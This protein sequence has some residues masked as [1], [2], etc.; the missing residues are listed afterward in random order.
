MS[1]RREMKWKTKYTK[2]MG[3]HVEAVRM[4]TGK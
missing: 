2:E 3:R 1:L 4:D